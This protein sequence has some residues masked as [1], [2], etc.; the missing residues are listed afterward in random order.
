MTILGQRIKL[1]RKKRG[2]TQDAL[3]LKIKEKM[4]TE[5]KV[6]KLQFLIMKQAIVRHLMKL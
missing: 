5:T 4:D 2:L 1:S 6:T 3:A